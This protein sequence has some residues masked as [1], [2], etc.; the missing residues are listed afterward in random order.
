MLQFG[1]LTPMLP[2]SPCIFSFA[3]RIQT[4]VRNKPFW[5]LV[6]R[7]SHLVGLS[8]LLTFFSC[9]T[10]PND[11]VRQIFQV[12]PPNQ[13]V[14]LHVKRTKISSKILNHLKQK[15]GL[16]NLESDQYSFFLKYATFLP[17]KEIDT[18]V[19]SAD[20]KRQNLIFGGRFS[21]KL[22][23]R[24]FLEAQITC[25]DALN[26]TPCIFPTSDEKHQIKATMPNHNTLVLSKSIQPL[27]AYA[28]NLSDSNTLPVEIRHSVQ[29]EGVAYASI[30]PSRLNQILGESTN[31]SLKLLLRS[32][33]P[34]K[35]TYL[36]LTTPKLINE[37][38]FS[39]LVLS[40]AIEYGTAEMAQNQKGILEG[41]S[42]LGASVINLQRGSSDPWN[43]ILRSGKFQHEGLKVY[44]EWTLGP[45]FED[46]K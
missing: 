43:R 16:Y 28:T 6:R 44:A 9:K 36:V 38:V 8:L 45:I 2:P 23:L 14:I 4:A 11:P 21:K 42:V 39:E 46:L 30:I 40:A 3:H 25:A 19:F 22:L 37:L 7:P 15:I 26:S 24:S 12:L 27:L 31:S 29:R 35:V 1:N 34:S 32:L 20:E 17:L 33:K 41:L 5:L 13:A 18:L 10:P